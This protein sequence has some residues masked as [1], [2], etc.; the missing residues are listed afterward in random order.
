TRLVRFQDLFIETYGGKDYI[1]KKYL[2]RLIILLQRLGYRIFIQADKDGKNKDKLKNYREHEEINE[3]DEF[4]FRVDFETAFPSEYLFDS[5]ITLGI[6]VDVPKDEFIDTLNEHKNESVLT[7]IKNQFSID[8][9]DKKVDLA[10]KLADRLIED[11]PFREWDENK[12]SEIALFIKAL[13]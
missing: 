4:Q 5:I 2:I 3:F 13:R 8:L 11:Y 9:S 10:E 6:N 7:V 1:R 12:N